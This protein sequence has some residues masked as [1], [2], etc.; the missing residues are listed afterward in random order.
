MDSLNKLQRK[1]IKTA[2]KVGTK[3]ITKCQTFRQLRIVAKAIVLE[4]LRGVQRVDLQVYSA[5]D[6]SLWCKTWKSADKY[7]ST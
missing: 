4:K 5:K 6:N 3:G 7:L 1:I 2:K